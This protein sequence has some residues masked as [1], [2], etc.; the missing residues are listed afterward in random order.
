MESHI[1]HLVA[2]SLSL[3]AAL[4]LTMSQIEVWVK[5]IVCAIREQSIE[6]ATGYGKVAFFWVL[7]VLSF[8]IK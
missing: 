7:V 8:I 2:I 5:R 6:Y 3:W 4:T 1:Y